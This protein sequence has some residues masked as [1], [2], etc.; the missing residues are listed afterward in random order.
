L[1]YGDLANWFTVNSSFRQ[2]ASATAQNFPIQGLDPGVYQGI[3]KLIGRYAPGTG[4]LTPYKG[5]RLE[6]NNNDMKALAQDVIKALGWREFTS[7]KFKVEKLA[8]FLSKFINLI[9]EHYEYTRKLRTSD[10][11]NMYPKSA[12]VKISIPDNKLKAIEDLARHWKEVQQSIGKDKGKVTEDNEATEVFSSIG[13]NERKGQNIS[14]VK[15]GSKKRV[16]GNKPI[17]KATV[18]NDFEVMYTDRSEWGVKH[19]HNRYTF[20][21]FALPYHSEM[22]RL[23]HLEPWELEYGGNNYKACVQC[24]AAYYAIGVDKFRGSHGQKFSSIIPQ[25]VRENSV[26]LSRFLGPN[27]WNAIKDLP[28]KQLGAILDLIERLEQDAIDKSKFTEKPTLSNLW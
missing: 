18:P 15:E 23:H 1:E 3:L 2:T 5:K 22:Q 26:Y 14:V 7:S 21:D 9:G 4:P 25:K 10:E 11:G 8:N 13:S 6:I 20:S 19:G 12:Y 28:A 27:L 16:Y 24:M 17:V